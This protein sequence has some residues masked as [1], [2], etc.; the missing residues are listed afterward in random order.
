M[1]LHLLKDK[2]KENKFKGMG[3]IF[4]HF[5]FLSFDFYLVSPRT[6]EQWLAYHGVINPSLD[7]CPFQ[8]SVL[9]S[10]VFIVVPCGILCS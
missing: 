9:L 5:H 2:N 6:I 3:F 7:T 4:F 8:N 10:G 1:Q